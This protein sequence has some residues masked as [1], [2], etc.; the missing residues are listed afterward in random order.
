MFVHHALD[1]EKLKELNKDFGQVI[2]V[3][4]PVFFVSQGNSP[5]ETNILFYFSV[6]SPSFILL[7]A[8]PRIS[9]ET[10]YIRSAVKV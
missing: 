4:Q 9:T 1:P 7:L 5:C 2:P 8:I 3:G 6:L 10:D